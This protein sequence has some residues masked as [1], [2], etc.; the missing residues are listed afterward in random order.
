[1]A[2]D[3][4]VG[5]A[6]ARVGLL[7][8]AVT[9]GMVAEVDVDDAEEGRSGR[10]EELYA[11][12]GEP[13]PVLEW[14]D[15]CDWLDSLAML[16]VEDDDCMAAAARHRGRAWRWSQWNHTGRQQRSPQ[17]ELSYDVMLAYDGSTR[18]MMV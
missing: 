3:E 17:C 18:W 2:V 12:E 8:G 6:G 10:G 9:R 14:A 5:C 1:M 4:L 11:G 16:G 15:N 7:G 13:E